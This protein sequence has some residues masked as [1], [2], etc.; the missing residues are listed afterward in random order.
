MDFF[1]PIFKR[2]QIFEFSPDRGGI[3]ES[4]WLSGGEIKPKAGTMFIKMPIV[5]LQK[6][7]TPELLIQG[8]ASSYVVYRNKD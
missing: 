2:S 3:L 6:N 5:M 4:R 1:V 8:F 7:K